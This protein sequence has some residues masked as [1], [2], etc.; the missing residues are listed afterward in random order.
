MS[1]DFRQYKVGEFQ[2]LLTNEKVAVIGAGG[3]G[4]ELLKTLV[5][6]GFGHIV[7]VF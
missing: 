3:I 5:L 7:I 1:I 6:L 4:C 2:R